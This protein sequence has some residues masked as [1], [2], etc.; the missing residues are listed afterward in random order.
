[1]FVTSYIH[2]RR[3]VS[4]DDAVDVVGVDATGSDICTA[5]MLA[6][7]E[8]L[9]VAG[10]DCRNVLGWLTFMMTSLRCDCEVPF[11]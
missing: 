11:G 2:F 7:R 1:M 8:P 9:S 5:L 10:G 6:V 3:H 4:V